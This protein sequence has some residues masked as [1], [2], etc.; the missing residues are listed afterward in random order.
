MLE[1]Y[2][3]EN[4]ES[5]AEFARRIDISKQYL[6]YI[7]KE[8]SKNTSAFVADKINKETGLSIKDYLNI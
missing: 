2:I 8:K 4:Y 7:L 3:K 6:D 5:K 1:K